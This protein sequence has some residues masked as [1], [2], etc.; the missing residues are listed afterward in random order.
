MKRKRDKSNFVL[1]LLKKQ[2]QNGTRHRSAFTAR[3]GEEN[4]EKFKK[5]SDCNVL[6]W[7][8]GWYIT[9][10]LR[11]EKSLGY[12]EKRKNGGKKVAADTALFMLI[13]S[14]SLQSKKKKRFKHERSALLS[15][16]SS[17]DWNSDSRQSSQKWA[18]PPQL[19]GERSQSK[20][21]INFRLPRP[22]LLIKPLTL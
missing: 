13:M 8:W 2:G 9:L 16:L 17:A 15:L 12:R 1:S 14:L 18:L 4:A 6:E 19:K 11:R 3:R 7:T 20:D 21:G 22:L 10:P 5:I